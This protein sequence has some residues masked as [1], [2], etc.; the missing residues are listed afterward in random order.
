M[1]VILEKVDKTKINKNCCFNIVNQNVTEL[2]VLFILEE[3][4]LSFFM[5]Y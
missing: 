4:V 2:L 1:D 3:V 5:G